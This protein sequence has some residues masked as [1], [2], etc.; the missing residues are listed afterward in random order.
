MI[1]LVMSVCV[2]ALPH[3][4]SRVD[5]TFSEMDVTVMQCLMSA[6]AMAAKWIDEHPGTILG[7]WSC[8][9]VDRTAA[10]I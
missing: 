4:C 2:A 9:A 6:P 10:N 1:A 5:L 7:R 8:E 3:Q